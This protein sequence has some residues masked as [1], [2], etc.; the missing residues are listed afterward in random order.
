MDVYEDWEGMTP[1]EAEALAIGLAEADAEF[2]TCP[3]CGGNPNWEDYE[4]A[5]TV[6]EPQPGEWGP[7]RVCNGAGEVRA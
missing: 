7:C 2:V 4:P 1:A 3:R 6:G 5:I